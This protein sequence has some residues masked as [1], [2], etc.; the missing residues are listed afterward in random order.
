MLNLPMTPKPNQ[1]WS[2]A[3]MLGGVKPPVPVAEL[4]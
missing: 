3:E 1:E 4:Y 2:V